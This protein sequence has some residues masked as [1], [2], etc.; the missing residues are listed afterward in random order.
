MVRCWLHFPDLGNGW[1]ITVLE[2]QNEYDFMKQEQRSFR[3]SD[4]Y[5]ISGTTNIMLGET[6]GYSDYIHNNSGKLSRY[7]LFQID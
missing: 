3:K 6:V 4:S 2:T 1:G 7:G 5:W